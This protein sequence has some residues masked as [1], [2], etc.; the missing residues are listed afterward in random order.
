MR[1]RQRPLFLIDLA[2]PRDVKPAVHHLQGVYLYDLDSLEGIAAKGLQA[3]R[4][5]AVLGEQLVLRHGRDFSDWLERASTALP[6]LVSGVMVIPEVNF[7]SSR[8]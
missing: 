3:R 8:A 7:Y 6:A 2:M 1:R 4:W 5:E